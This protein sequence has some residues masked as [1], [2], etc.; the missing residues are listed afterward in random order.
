LSGLLNIARCILTRGCLWVLG[1]NSAACGLLSVQVVGSCVRSLLYFRGQSTLTP[2]TVSVTVH[3]ISFT[4]ALFTCFTALRSAMVYAVVVS[5]V[6][7]SQAC[8]VPKWINV[9]RDPT[10]CVPDS[11]GTSFLVQNKISRDSNGG[12]K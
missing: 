8:T 9:K 4:Y 12:A 2:R 7:P 3:S 6:C 5:V 11:P 1:I 10:Q